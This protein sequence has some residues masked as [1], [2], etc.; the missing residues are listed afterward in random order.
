[1]LKIHFYSKLLDNDTSVFLQLSYQGV[2][3][4]FDLR[5][6]SIIWDWEKNIYVIFWVQPKTSPCFLCCVIYSFFFPEQLPQE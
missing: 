1:M 4:L 2:E 5:I 3:I 6:G